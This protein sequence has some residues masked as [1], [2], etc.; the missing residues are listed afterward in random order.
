MDFSAAQCAAIAELMGKNRA[1][2]LRF[3]EIERQHFRHPA[4]DDFLA[5]MLRR[6]KAE[7]GIV[8]LRN[9]PLAGYSLAEIESIYWGIGTHFGRACSQSSAG[10]LMGHVTDKGTSRGY[11]GSRELPM[12]SDSAELVGLLCVRRS[13]EG[14]ENML[15]SAIK[16][17]E[18]I[19]QEHPEYLPILERGFP[20][21]RR[22]EEA[23]DAEPITPYD[24]PIF[25]FAEGVLSC[26]CTRERIDLALRDLKRPMTLLEEAALDFFESVAVR[27]GVCFHLQLEPGEVLFIDNFEMLHSRTAFVDWE[28]PARKRLMLRLWLEGEPRRPLKREM[29]TFQNKSG[30]LGIDPQD[31]RQVGRAEF[32]PPRMRSPASKSVA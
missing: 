4:L 27:P 16:V 24:V 20:Y 13:R 10:D 15:A 18:I 29:L 21:H 7:P 19:K 5:E 26:R 12:H 2:G 14:G 8:V 3:W 22:G 32:M 25:S 9:F 11:T 28:E 1:A 31:G 6:M 30:R 17:Y 23:P